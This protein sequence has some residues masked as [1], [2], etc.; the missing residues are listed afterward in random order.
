LAAIDARAQ[1][2]TSDQIDALLLKQF[3]EMTQQ[4]GYF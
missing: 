2:I 4:M 3:E 1:G